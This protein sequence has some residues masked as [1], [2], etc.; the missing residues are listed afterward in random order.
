MVL[1][2]SEQRETTVQAAAV[3]PISMSATMLRKM[4]TEIEADA[5]V[6]MIAA[7]IGVL[8]YEYTGLPNST[9][10]DIWESN[11]QLIDEQTV[12][13]V[14]SSDLLIFRSTYCKDHT[15]IATGLLGHLSGE[16]GSLGDRP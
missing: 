11:E 16:H 8:S 4:Q 15:V 9:C 7:L 12:H 1:H 6:T 14:L 13:E 2:A 5:I 10:T 3:N